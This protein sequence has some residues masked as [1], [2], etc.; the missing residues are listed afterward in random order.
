MTVQSSGTPPIPWPWVIPPIA[1]P[2][3][4]LLF[5]IGCGVGFKDWHVAEGGSEGP[6]KL[7]G[8]KALDIQ[9]AKI[10]A[11][12]IAVEVNNFLHRLPSGTLSQLEKAARDRA[13]AVLKTLSD[14]GGTQP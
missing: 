7:Q 2:L 9:H 8:Y 12:E 10:K 13:L 1:T 3:G 6:R 5:L 14:L 4:Y 11:K